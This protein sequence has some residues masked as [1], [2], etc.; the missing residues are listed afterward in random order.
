MW[1]VSESGDD[2]NFATHAADLKRTHMYALRLTTAG[3]TVSCEC[4]ST[5]VIARLNLDL[6]VGHNREN[7]IAKIG[8]STR[9]NA[10]LPRQL[11]R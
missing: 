3:A 2:Y 5:D 4:I 9:L 1:I 11:M 7:Q 10:C 6:F 8:L